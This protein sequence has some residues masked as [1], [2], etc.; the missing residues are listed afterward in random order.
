MPR[1]SESDLKAYEQ[2]T[3]QAGR[4]GVGRSPIIQKLENDNAKKIDHRPEKAK[5]DG[6]VH[7][8]FTVSI[9]FRFFD[10]RKRD[11]DGCTSTALDCLVK[12][13]QTL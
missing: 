11:L 2:R 1:W 4:A 7:P 9:T 8:T 13:L 6:T 12:A 10:N 3:N 5:V